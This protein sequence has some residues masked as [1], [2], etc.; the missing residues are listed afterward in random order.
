MDN[1]VKTP[2]EMLYQWEKQTPNKVYLRQPIN[3]EWQ[4]YTWAQVADQARRMAAAI[5]SMDLPPKSCIA[6]AGRNTAHWFMADFAIQMAGHISVGLYPKQATETVNYIL[7]HC[8]AK[9]IFIGPMDD[10]ECITDGIPEGVTR[11]TFPYPDVAPADTSWDALIGANE[12]LAGEP[13]P[14]PEDIFTLIYTSG[15]TGNPKGVTLSYNN[16]MTAVPGASSVIEINDSDRLFSYLPLAHI[17]E[18]AVVELAS[19]YHNVQISFLEELKKFPTQL[20]MVAPTMFVAVPAV[21]TRLQ[22]GILEKMPQKKL[23]LLLRIPILNNLIRKKIKTAL[24]LQNVRFAISG[25]AP[26]PVS[27]LEWWDRMGVTIHEGYAMSENTAY[28]FINYPG[29]A[30][31]GSV[32]QALPDSEVKIADDGEILTRSGATMVGYYKQPDKTAEA[33]DSDGWLHTGDRGRVDEDGY[34]FITGRVKDI[35]KTIKGKYVAPAPIEG[36]FGSNSDIESL[37]MVGA[38]L[39]QPVLL[40]SLSEEGQH[41]DRTEVEAGLLESLKNVNATLE[42]HEVIDSIGICAQPW[43]IDNGLLTPTMKIKRNVVEDQYKPLVEQCVAAGR[44]KVVWE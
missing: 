42:A 3:D 2:I 34:L 10:P 17:F 21:W 30:R 5:Q 26:I 6:I 1:A 24:G 14:N 33:I 9:V 7:N 15:T 13:K 16:I 19:L 38:G 35:F 11:I 28:A 20:P 27:T 29:K 18:R 37:C 32:G 8:E 22:H 36:K 4:E 41:K 44:G 23:N 40:V 31:F 43:T 39:K 12:P 25:A